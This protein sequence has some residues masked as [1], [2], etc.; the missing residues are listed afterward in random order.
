MTTV[1]ALRAR[2][3]SEAGLRNA[4]ESAGLGPAY[5]ALAGEWRA[6]IHPAS[7]ADRLCTPSRMRWF[8]CSWNRA[9]GEPAPRPVPCSGTCG[10]GCGVKP[11]G[12][13]AVLGPTLVVVSLTAPRRMFPRICLRDVGRRCTICGT[14]HLLASRAVQSL[15]LTATVPAL[16][17][18]FACLTQYY[19]LLLTHKKVGT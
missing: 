12:C 10:L 6:R 1:R 16:P 9:S 2:D 13:K 8:S 15:C 11:R 19:P 18:S 14:R 17:L 4:A 5:G 7:P 3:C